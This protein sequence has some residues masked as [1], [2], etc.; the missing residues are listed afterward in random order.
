M[1]KQI[2]ANL[3]QAIGTDKNVKCSCIGGACKFVLPPNS[4]GK[5]TITITKTDSSAN[6]ITIYPAK[7][8][9]LDDGTRQV[10]T[11]TVVGTVTKTGN[12]T[13]VVT[14]AIMPASPL[15]ISVPVLNADTAAIVAGKIRGVF[16]RTSAITDMF[17]VSGSGATVVL[18]TI[19]YSGNDSTLNISTDNDTCEGLTT[20]A[21]STNTTAGVAVTIASQ[22][23][24]KTFSNNGTSWTIT[25]TSNPTS[26]FSGII[27]GTGTAGIF[28]T[29]GATWVN[30]ATAGQC[31]A[32]L[33]CSTSA[34]SGDFATLRMRARADAAGNASA[35]N[36]S[37]SA[38][39]NNYGDLRAVEGYAQPNAYTNNSAANIVCGVYSCIDRT[40][41]GTSSGRDWSTWIDTHMQVKASG[42]SYL[43]RLSHNG[44]VANDGVITVYNGGRM[45]IL[46]NFEDA[47]GFLTE[48]GDAGSTKA[49]YLAVKTPAGTKYIQLVTA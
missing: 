24:Y 41:G 35:G 2:S 16:G 48:T 11:A 47:A 30:F 37:A 29:T 14:S 33:L 3:Y 7:H 20:G 26:D 23:S 9:T 28:V 22:N 42:G 32:K 44:T 45:P 46:F 21:T 39:A 6:A 18:T 8:E 38:G 10:E 1:S 19:E 40:T 12:A 5:N 31:A 15:T 4:D 17:D 13:V 34:T 43:L 49:G 25:D 36:F 27:V